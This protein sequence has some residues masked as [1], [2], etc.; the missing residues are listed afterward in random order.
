M[1][2][3]KEIREEFRKGTK[4]TIQRTAEKDM[5]ISTTDNNWQ[6]AKPHQADNRTE[7]TTTETIGFGKWHHAKT[8]EKETEQNWKMV[9]NFEL[10]ETNT[11]HPPKKTRMGKDNNVE[12][13]GV[14]KHKISWDIST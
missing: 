13:L 11:I 3:N 5:L 10:T 1:G 14:G 9:R 2:Y 6:I 8:S 12:Y 7:E 4:C